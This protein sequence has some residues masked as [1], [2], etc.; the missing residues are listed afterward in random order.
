MT[1]GRPTAIGIDPSHEDFDRARRGWNAMIDRRPALIARCSSVDDVVEAVTYAARAGR[2]AVAR[3]G[4]HSVSGAS[5]IDGGVVI[6]LAGLKDIAVDPDARIARVGGGALLGELDA[7]TQAHGLAVTAGV[8][9]ETGVGG[10]TLGGGIGFLARKLGLTID[11]LVG[12]QVVLAD[13]SVVEASESAHPDLFWALRGGGGQFGVVTRFD[14]QV[15]PV[16]PQIVTAWA[17]YPLDR[18]REVMR[19][20]REYMNDASDDVSLVPAFMKAPPTDAFPAEWHGK[21]CTAVVALHLGDEDEANA[22]LQ[23]LLDLDDLIT[24]FIAPQPYV[25]FQKAFAGASP[26]GGRFYWKSIF[27]DD[28]SDELVDVMVDG[29]RTIP[30]EYSMVFMETLGGAVSRVGVT[31][32]AFSNR[33]ARYNVGISA[34]WAD[35]A[36]DAEAMAAARAC[37]ERLQPFSDG[38]VYLNYLDR[39]EG[40]RVRKGFGPNFDRLQSIKARYDPGGLF[41][42]VLATG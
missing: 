42:G 22:D 23:P 28:L 1:N 30:G 38:T 18:A 16:G 11:N 37:F 27:V 40:D 8:E 14:F 31:D 13:G 25:E 2:Q 35:P 26:H 19:F 12:A 41:P 39:D 24:G 34:G 7:A 15:H 20:V 5:L 32:T 36:L 6:D 33:S 21:P 17:F 3:C 9:P 10:L 4:G 29:V